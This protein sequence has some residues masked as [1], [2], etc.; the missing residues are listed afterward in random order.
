M[1]RCT[2]VL[3]SG[4]HSYRTLRVS[5]EEWVYRLIEE[6]VYM[7]EWAHLAPRME[8]ALRSGCVWR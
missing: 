2:A 5:V 4:C 6:W 1:S 8:C 7:E 3:K